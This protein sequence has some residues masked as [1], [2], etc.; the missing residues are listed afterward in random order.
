M[1]SKDQIKEINYEIAYILRTN[2]QMSS[3][4]VGQSITMAAYMLYRASKTYKGDVSNAS[5]S[6]EDIK[7]HKLISSKRTVSAIRLLVREEAWNALIPLLDKYSADAFKNVIF[8]NTED[9]HSTPN[10]LIRL[11]QRVLNIDDND[12]V[13]DIGCGSGNFLTS[14]A[15]ATQRASYY[16]CE[17][18]ITASEIASIRAEILKED[19]PHIDFSIESFDAFVLNQEKDYSG[20]FS[21]VFSNYPFGMMARSGSG[22][23]YLEY[24]TEQAPKVRRVRSADWLYNHLAIELLT[25]EG[26]A[27]VIMPD[28]GLFNNIDKDIRAY[29]VEQGWIESIVKLPER[30][31]NY[32]GIGT[33]L[34]VLSKG[35]KS[36]RFVNASHIFQQERRIR[37]FSDSDVEAIVRMLDT[38]GDYSVAADCNTVLKNDSDLMVT[39]YLKIADKLVEKLNSVALS[40]V[41]ETVLRGAP[42]SAKALDE[43]TSQ[44]ETDC[45]YLMLQN[46]QDGRVDADLPYLSEISE[47]NRK[48]CLRNDDLIL[49]KNNAPF[50]VAVVKVGKKRIV[51]NGNL[52]VL[53][54]NKEKVL[55]HYLQAYFQSES[56]QRAL[57]S[58][59]NG[60]VL[61]S[62]SVDALRK[63]EIPVPPMDLQK[64]VAD[65]FEAKIHEL[66]MLE[67]R[68]KRVRRVLG[69]IFE[70]IVEASIEERNSN[71]D[72]SQANNG[73]TEEVN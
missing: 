61:K 38:D 15:L 23:G 28:G 72:D 12:S 8:D 14:T 25:D 43:L 3:D 2:Q 24:V 58:I 64:K 40:S 60:T 67:N 22:A 66:A 49:S 17:L 69:S 57:E 36:I 33:N 52:Y 16:G 26:K 46:I 39:S 56:G 29:F 41:T 6:Y 21:K 47:K 59:S 7:N 1:Y 18:S 55:P 31:F 32:T 48:Y 10:S 50:K 44:E 27:V 51:A 53:R 71:T 45:Q 63:L 19:N 4:T 65:E 30:L 54:L 73:M 20:K 34:M 62:I 70:E 9:M 42:L 68:M 37:V 13:A 35:N 11:A 5:I